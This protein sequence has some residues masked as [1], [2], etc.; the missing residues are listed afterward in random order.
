MEKIIEKIEKELRGVADGKPQKALKEKMG[1]EITACLLSTIVYTL[2]W[3]S[4][5]Y[6]SALRLAG[7]KLGKRLGE[8]SEKTEFSLVL[9]EI[10]RILKALRGGKVEAGIVPGSRGA[11]IKIYDSPVTKETPNVLQNLC[12][13]EEGFIEGYIDGA[14]AK[15]GPLAISG[16]KFAVEKVSV[17][18]KRC[19]GLGDDHCGF[20]I[21]F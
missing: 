2:Q 14:V 4:V 1:E 20:L 5:G 8:G 6:Q 16:E 21:K 19:V 9:E 15:K 13:F 7:M 3:T 12:F 11:Q 10:R 17:E 18:E